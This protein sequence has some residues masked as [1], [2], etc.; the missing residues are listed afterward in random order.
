VWVNG[1]P[2][3]GVATSRAQRRAKRTTREQEEVVVEEEEKEEG[4]EEKKNRV[5][6]EKERGGKNHWNC[7]Y[8]LRFF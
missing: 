2:H 5:V 1:G 7:D 4:E 6:G 8:F 3:F